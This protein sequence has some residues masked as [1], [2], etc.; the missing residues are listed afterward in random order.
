MELDSR[1]IMLRDTGQIDESI[2]KD[3]L[4]IISMF[5]KKWNI[6]LTEENGAMLITHI[7]IAFQRIKD[8]KKIGN[9]DENIIAELKNNKYFI[10][11]SE[12][13]KD[14][15]NLININIPENEKKFIAMHL[16]VLFENEHIKII[17]E[18]E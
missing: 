7:S 11:A 15:E 17:K 10:K 18:G 5:K 13:I 1:L 14:M 9:I 16:C 12:C 2:Y 6:K 3:I 8:G 4:N